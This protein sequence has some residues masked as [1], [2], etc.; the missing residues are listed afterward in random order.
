[1]VNNLGVQA[2]HVTNMR[3]VRANSLRGVYGLWKLGIHALQEQQSEKLKRR[4]A[5]AA[6]CAERLLTHVQF[7]GE[8]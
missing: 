7:D 3:N 5:R 4:L 6:E 2:R 1:M 8:N